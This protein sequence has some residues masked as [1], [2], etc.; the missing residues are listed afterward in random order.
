MWGTYRLLHALRVRLALR[1]L[2]GIFNLRFVVHIPAVGTKWL[3][4]VG[5][6][7]IERCISTTLLKNCALNS[8][9]TLQLTWSPS[10]QF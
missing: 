6:D 8:W 9:S 3:H 4:D 1:R 2:G 10:C 7:A 5:T